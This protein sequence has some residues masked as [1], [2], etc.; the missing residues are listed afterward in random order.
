MSCLNTSRKSFSHTEYVRSFIA[1]TSDLLLHTEFLLEEMSGES[2][3]CAALLNFMQSSTQ[4]QV[5][6]QMFEQTRFLGDIILRPALG[7]CPHE[8]SLLVPF[9]D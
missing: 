3:G 7:I 4:P 1:V 6:A 8:N 2:S 5:D 9:G